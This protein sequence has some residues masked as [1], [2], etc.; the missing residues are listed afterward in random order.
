MKILVFGLLLVTIGV[1]DDAI[2]AEEISSRP[3]VPVLP[4]SEEPL[5]KSA[6]LSEKLTVDKSRE[7]LS[8]QED[9]IKTAKKEEL[10]KN[11]L[12]G[13]YYDY[14]N[15]GKTFFFYETMPN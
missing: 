10:P 7:E 3:E 9:M 5:L 1:C 12:S 13:R 11:T 6:P 14:T 8:E 15:Y 4:Q 2:P